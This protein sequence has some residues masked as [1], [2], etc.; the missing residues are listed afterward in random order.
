MK[1]PLLKWCGSLLLAGMGWGSSAIAGELIGWGAGWIGSSNL[2][3]DLTNIVSF[4]AHDGHTVVLRSDGTVTNF[5]LYLWS[6]NHRASLF[7]PPGLG[8][9]LTVVAGYGHDEVLDRDGRVIAWGYPT[10]PATTNVPANLTN[11]AA[12][13]TSYQNSLALTTEGSLV[14]WAYGFFGL[15]NIPEGLANNVVKVAA[16]G[17]HFLALKA[18]GTVAAWGDNR[19]GQATVP[20]GLSN[21]ISIAGAYTHSLA[22]KADGTVAAWGDN[23]YG[24]SSVPG[25]T[26]AVA[27]AATGYSS[28]AIR[29]DGS[30]VV[31][32]DNYYGQRIVPVAVTNVAAVAG[33]NYNNTALVGKVAPRPT[34]LPSSVTVAYGTRILLSPSV[35][36]TKPLAYQWNFNGAEL[37]GATRLAMSLENLSFSNAG[38]YEVVVRNSLGAAT[39]SFMV[40]VAP[41]VIAAQPKSQRVF[42]STAAAFSVT[43]TGVTPIHYQWLLDGA[44]LPGATSSSLILSNTLPEQAG[45]YSVVVSNDYT[46]LTSSNAL[47]EIDPLGILGQ[48]GDRSVVQRG[49]TTFT[50]TAIGASPLRYQWQ[51]NGM[52]LAGATNS[53]LVL[54]DVQ[55]TQAGAYAA[56]VGNAYATLQSATGILS[57]TELAGWGGNFYGQVDLPPAPPSIVAIAA[58]DRSSLALR[59]DGTVV[60]WGD[61]S[62]GQ[63]TAPG[64]LTNVVAIA[65]GGFFNLALRA[66]GGVVAWGDNSFGQTNVPPDLTNVVA[67]AGGTSHA[68][69]LTSQGRVFAW[70]RNT[71]GQAEIPLNLSN[72][73]AIAGGRYHSLALE[74]DGTVSTWGDNS[75]GQLNLP[76]GLTNVA[77]IACGSRH[78]LA[79]TARGSAVAWGDNYYGQTEVPARTD[80]VAITANFYNNL[81]LTVDGRVVAWGNNLWGQTNVPADLSQVVGIACGQ[82]HSLTLVGNSPPLV[83]SWMVDPARG[84][85]EF[86][87]RLQTRSGRVYALESKSSLADSNWTSFPL[88]AGIA[89]ILKLT[90][91]SA[92]NSQR[93][94]RVREW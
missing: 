51:F 52:G 67:I 79:L 41:L 69:A 24:Q 91:A 26:N 15:M 44:A 89:G 49:T 47:L 50:V 81:A 93:L 8:D 6:D 48:P 43:A 23:Y 72:V 62:Y 53:S 35:I 28:L 73:V 20:P 74:R 19:F 34:A 94:Y 3:P 14:A 31:W 29:A 82:Y 7:V 58:G 66:D 5:G 32:G 21:V 92:T 30:L 83:H 18:D 37:P 11:A 22:L 1:A 56:L 46:T 70:G 2:P 88:A 84:S 86:T 64:D 27:I 78:S 75:S 90:D 85:G 57:V 17:F 76:S 10:Y 65:A 40:K 55:L 4:S 42:A 87:L 59:T 61:N 38:T 12:I 54:K 71:E 68:L 9:V 36:G 33:G 13:A 63:G 77:A 45:L 16:G 80:L 60:A 39:N 25:L